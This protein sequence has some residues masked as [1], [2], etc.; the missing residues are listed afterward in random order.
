VSIGM[1]LGARK[2]NLRSDKFE[3]SRTWQK[4]GKRLVS[5]N[6][7]AHKSL[8]PFTGQLFEEK[9]NAVR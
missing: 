6:T 3:A 8:L 1:K 9:N 4:S 5:A 7:K 2:H